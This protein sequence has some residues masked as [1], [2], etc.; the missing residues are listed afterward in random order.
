LRAL[1]GLRGETLDR[2]AREEISRYRNAVHVPLDFETTPE[3]FAADGYHPS[4]AGY[5]E[6]GEMVARLTADRFRAIQSGKCV[7]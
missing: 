6:L 5:Q 2:I 1:F 3:R 4:E 7:T